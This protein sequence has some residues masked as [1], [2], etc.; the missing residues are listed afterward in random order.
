[1]ISVKIANEAFERIH[2]FGPFDVPEDHLQRFAK[3]MATI[4]RFIVE[5]DVPIEIA[6]AIC[7]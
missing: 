4:K 3:D 1:M 7:D 6:E 5:R 2:A